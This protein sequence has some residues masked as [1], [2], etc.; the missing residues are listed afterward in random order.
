MKTQNS[1]CD[2]LL[3][4]AK[5]VVN[6]LSGCVSTVFNEKKTKMNVARSI[7]SLGKSLTKLTFN[8]GYCVV[9]NTPKA[10]VAVA[11]A[12]REFISAIEDEIREHKK[13]Q[14]E[15]ALNEKIKQLR[16]KA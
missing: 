9:K 1:D 14:K 10:V 6:D 3:G 16:L 15:A 8:A 13:H 4:N 7:F 2:I 12:K 5:G 11:V